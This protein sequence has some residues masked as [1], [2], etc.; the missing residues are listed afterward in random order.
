MHDLILN[1]VNMHVLII[2][3]S[4][5]IRFFYALHGAWCILGIG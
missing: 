1:F 4:L 3:A 2:S 5:I